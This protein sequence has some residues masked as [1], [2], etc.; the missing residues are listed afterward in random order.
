M[1]I[2]TSYNDVLSSPA[3]AGNIGA[4]SSVDASAPTKK[5][6]G[7]EKNTSVA[8]Q[9]ASGRP[10]GDTRTADEI[11]QDNPIV[12]NALHH[13]NQR[14]S[15]NSPVKEHALIEDLKRQVGDFTDENKDPESQADAM[16]NLAHVFNFVNA[17]SRLSRYSLEP[18]D[19]RL[20]QK[21]PVG[22]SETEQMRLFSQKGHPFLTLPV[23]PENTG[24]APD[25]TR[26]VEEI[27]ANPLF[28]S[29]FDVVTP[30]LH[31]DFKYQ[32]GGDWNDPKLDPD[33]RADI[34][35]NAERVLKRIDENAG[36]KPTRNDGK[37]DSEVEMF[38]DIEDLER[39]HAADIVNIG[40]H[41]SG[42]K[43]YAF[44][45]SQ[46][47]VLFNFSKEGHSALPPL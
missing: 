35:A 40:G 23:H 33:T 41:I 27:T 18:E 47:H 34:A 13:W 2:N 21:G 42:Y 3:F 8:P 45:D 38:K 17:D 25:D 28:K 46:L 19:N 29:Y 39:F 22:R 31:R 43:K 16:F 36:E 26:S 4:A 10:S 11:R 30:S 7:A 37:I 5:V 32:V 20:E 14:T 1:N 15:P 44:K 6:P 9:S 24:R 12:G